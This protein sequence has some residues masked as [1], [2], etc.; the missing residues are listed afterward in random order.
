MKIESWKVHSRKGCLKEIWKSIMSSKDT[1]T[2]MMQAGT[3]ISLGKRFS[4]FWLREVVDVSK[5]ASIS[6]LKARTFGHLTKMKRQPKQ[7]Q[8]PPKLDAFSPGLGVISKL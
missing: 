3:R 5:L 8:K 4:V 7:R 2:S 6:P 1:D